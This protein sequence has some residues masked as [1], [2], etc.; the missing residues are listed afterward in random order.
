MDQ[1]SSS[2]S[3]DG[4]S[5]QLKSSEEAVNISDWPPL[6]KISQ[7]LAAY[8]LLSQLID[9]GIAQSI[10]NKILISH[11]SIVALPDDERDLLDLPGHFPFDIEVSA[12]GGL[13]ESDFKYQ[14]TF[15]SGGTKAFINP[16][17]IGSLLKITSDQE[18]TLVENQYLVLEAIDHRYNDLGR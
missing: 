1:I 7:D 14:Y 11:Q 4:F 18:Y 12:L 9:D 8:Q 17:R 13:T 16:K 3:N 15:L 2:V 10:N 6:L 5:Y